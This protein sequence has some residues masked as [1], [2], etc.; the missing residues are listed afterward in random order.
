MIADVICYWINDVINGARR[1]NVA[2]TLERRY[3]YMETYETL[4]KYWRESFRAKVESLKKMKTS[5]L[6]SS[7]IVQ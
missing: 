6:F 4:S 3:K 7:F 5:N 2:F 1:C